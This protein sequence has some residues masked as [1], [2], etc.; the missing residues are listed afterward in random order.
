MFGRHASYGGPVIVMQGMRPRW[1]RLALLLV[2]VGV[3][4][5]MPPSGYEPW[6]WA[7]APQ[8]VSLPV[9]DASQPTPLAGVS[10][11]VSPVA[12]EFR[13]DSASDAEVVAA[14][15]LANSVFRTAHERADVAALDGVATGAWLDEERRI[16]ADLRARGQLSCGRRDRFG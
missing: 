9:D 1:W 15:E 5:L 16:L 10:L 13:P 6:P 7:R 14:I 11:P 2:L 8:Q 4:V 12:G 3:V